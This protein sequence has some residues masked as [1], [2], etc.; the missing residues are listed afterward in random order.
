MRETST[1]SG[2]GLTDWLQL[3]SLGLIWGA[4]FTAVTVAGTDFG[5]LSISAWRIALGAVILFVL[6]KAMGLPLMPFSDHD[7]RKIWGAALG[8]GVFSMALP[9]YLLSWGQ[10]YVASG[11]AGV[12]MAAGPLLTLLLAHFLVPDERITAPKSIGIAIGFIGVVILIGLDAFES[13]GEGQE[14]LARLACLGAA[15]SYAIGAIITRRAPKTEPIAFAT[16][17]T[18]LAAAIMLPLALLSEGVPET[19]GLSATVAMVFLG[20]VPTALANLLLVATIRSAGPSFTSL[21]N[22]QVPVWSVIFGW[23]FL[24]EVLPSQV[25]VALGLIL[26][27]VAIS[28]SFRRRR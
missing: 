15:A 22:Y 1:T 9:F 7:G 25:F 10:V 19:F 27:G 5:P 8:L 14:S 4:S 23:A 21:V 16:A 28:Q 20:F 18:L 11:F 17:A 26:V 24:G 3:L 2:P 6:T 13:S 12:T